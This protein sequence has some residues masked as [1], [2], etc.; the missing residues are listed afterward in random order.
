[1][2]Q[3]FEKE[4]ILTLLEQL[5]N[6]YPSL[7]DDAMII[8]LQKK[9]LES[10][11][12]RSSFIKEIRGLFFYD[13]E[14]LNRFLMKYH[15]TRKI[16]SLKQ[17]KSFLEKIGSMSFRTFKITVVT[18]LALTVLANGFTCN[19][20]L[21]D[22]IGRALTIVPTSV[23]MEEL[24]YRGVKENSNLTEEQRVFFERYS[25]YLE[26]NPYL[27]KDDSYYNLKNLHIHE[28]SS[29]NKHIIASYDPQL[30]CI[31]MNNSAERDGLGD[32]SALEHEG[33]HLFSSNGRDS[34]FNK[35]D[36]LQLQISV[37]GN[38]LTEGM[39]QILSEE[40]FEKRG[41][42]ITRTYS[43]ETLLVKFIAELIGADVLLYGYSTHDIDIVIQK[44]GALDGDLSKARRLITVMDEILFLSKSGERQNHSDLVASY[45]DQIYSILKDYYRIKVAENE[46]KAPV[47]TYLREAFYH[48]ESASSPVYY[49]DFHKAYFSEQL[50]NQCDPYLRFDEE[51]YNFDE[52]FI[53][54]PLP[55]NKREYILENDMPIGLFL[56]EKT[57]SK[58]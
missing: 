13:E 21:G 14:R 9:C 53:E 26:E 23:S 49:Y 18:T 11:I 48:I 2:A 3:N 17:E 35:F 58:I 20:S 52:K 51:L 47:L 19:Y 44:L 5:K 6:V 36:V 8:S 57:K 38:S 39:T 28:V 43:E 34:G 40:Y 10:D 37:F 24:I 45:K 54:L 27:S 55:L 46:E 42:G 29:S 33:I 56:G 4:Q 22:P 1:M 30:D 41:S 15:V 16:P 50:K 7:L 32:E 25:T 12:E 31:I